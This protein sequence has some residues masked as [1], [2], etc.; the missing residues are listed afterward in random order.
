MTRKHIVIL[1]CAALAGALVGL[2]GQAVDPNGLMGLL[3]A[4]VAMYA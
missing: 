1:L 3:S 4:R 2:A